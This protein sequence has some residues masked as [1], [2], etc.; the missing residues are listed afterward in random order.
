MI[1][2]SPFSFSA[3][4]NEYMHSVA[5]SS[6]LML[7]LL[8]TI[9]D[10]LRQRVEQ[11]WQF[12][13]KKDKLSAIPLVAP[14][15]RQAFVNRN[16]PAYASVVIDSFTPLE[17]AKTYLVKVTVR[18]PFLSGDRPVDMSQTQRWVLG[19][20]GQWYVKLVDPASARPMEEAFG[21]KVGV[22][23]PAE[24]E[25]DPPRV[26]FQPSI[27]FR[28]LKLT[29][30]MKS[31]IKLHS[32]D[33]DDTVVSAELA[34]RELAPGESSTLVVTRKGEAAERAFVDVL[35]MIFLVGATQEKKVVR[36]DV[37]NSVL[38]EEN[39]RILDKLEKSGVPLGVPSA[40][41]PKQDPP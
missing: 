22:G 1:F 31:S 8:Q 18:A 34:R 39:K 30:N 20:D 16:D 4:R 23:A 40:Q 25:L 21:G 35:R 29:N 13:Q 12:L 6:L 28:E 17:D 33:F 7:V 14:E 10:E 41:K 27:A 19:H 37:V 36:V 26:I 38:S 9:P 15:S 24:L 5:V 3:H 32:I 11:Y 2:H